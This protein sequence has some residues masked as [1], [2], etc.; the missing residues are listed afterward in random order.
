MSTNT[1]DATYNIAVG[2]VIPI[3][4]A[5]DDARALL[6]TIFVLNRNLNPGENL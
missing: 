1:T 3:G 6:Q 5:L 4:H 2:A